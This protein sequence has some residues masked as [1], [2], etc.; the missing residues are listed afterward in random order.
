MNVRV[1]TAVA[2]VSMLGACTG[3]EPSLPAR[4]SH[5]EG[6]SAT[7]LTATVRNDSDR[8]IARI[9][10]VADFYQNF[11]SLHGTA[12]AA[13]KGG[14]DPDKERDGAFAFDTALPVAVSGRASRCIASRIEYLDGTSQELKTGP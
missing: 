8:P 9:R 5:C 1:L 2:A 6:Q 11:R 7:A 10:I 3:R 12:T 4:I 14:L 13:F